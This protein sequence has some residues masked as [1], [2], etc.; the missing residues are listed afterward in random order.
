MGV[1]GGV[2]NIAEMPLHGAPGN[3]ED[4]GQPSAACVRTDAAH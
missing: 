4:S 2:F 3:Q 1:K